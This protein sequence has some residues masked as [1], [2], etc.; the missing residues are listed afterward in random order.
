M[1]ESEDTADL[2]R[3]L[4]Q[5]SRTVGLRSKMEGFVEEHSGSDKV[6]KEI[7]RCDG[8]SMSEMVDEGREERI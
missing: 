1:S 7:R 2:G 4:L 8:G 5:K 3:R 6:L